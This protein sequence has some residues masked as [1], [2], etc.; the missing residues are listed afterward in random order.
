MS[1]DI[2]SFVEEA[3]GYVQKVCSEK[4]ELEAYCRQFMREVEVVGGLRMLES[5]R[6]GVKTRIL[7]STLERNLSLL[8]LWAY[9]FGY[10][11]IR[12]RLES[13]AQ[14]ARELRSSLG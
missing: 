6:S 14:R 8:A 4:R 11:D 13:L 2:R 12:T 3:M 9:K 10:A 5:F 1:D 7:L